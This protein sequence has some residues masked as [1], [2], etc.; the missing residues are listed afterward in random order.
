MDRSWALSPSTKSESLGW[1]PMFFASLQGNFSAPA[2]L[3]RP[4]LDVVVLIL[5]NK[6]WHPLIRALSAVVSLPFKIVIVLSDKTGQ[7]HQEDQFLTTIFTYLGY[8]FV[9]EPLP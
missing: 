8:F 1:G 3:E 4:A 7:G 6:A 9:T 5:P 2:S